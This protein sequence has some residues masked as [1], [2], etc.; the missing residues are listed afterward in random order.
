MDFRDVRRR[1]C[2]SYSQEWAKGISLQASYKL[3]QHVCYHNEKK[4][5]QKKQTQLYR[6]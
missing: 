6:R 3:V 2:P 5:K 1:I 4:T